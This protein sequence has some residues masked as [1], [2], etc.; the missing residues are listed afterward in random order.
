MSST[1]GYFSKIGSSF[2]VLN[3]A[4]FSRAKATQAGK[5]LK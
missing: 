4:R 1:V 2:Y 3:L 5:A